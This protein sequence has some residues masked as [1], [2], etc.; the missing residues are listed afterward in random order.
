[1][2]QTGLSP[3]L[4]WALEA[5]LPLA[6]GRFH[7]TGANRPAPLRHGLVVHPPRM[8]SEVVLFLSHR[9][10]GLATRRF[11]GSNLCQYHRFLAVA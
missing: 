8:A 2:A 4:A 7:R 9:F 1:M 3:K 5:A 6:T 10:T 11:Q